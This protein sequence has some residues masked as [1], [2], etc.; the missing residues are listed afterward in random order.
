MSIST[1]PKASF[2]Y[3]ELSANWGRLSAIAADSMRSDPAIAIA[4]SRKIAFNLSLTLGALESTVL[5]SVSCPAVAKYTARKIQSRPIYA[6]AVKHLWYRNVWRGGD[7]PMPAL[8]PRLRCLW[9]GV[10]IRILSGV[11]SATAADP[12]AD[13]IAAWQ[14]MNQRVVQAYQAGRVSV[15]VPLAQQAVALA[16]SSF[17][18]KDPR[19]LTSMNNLAEVLEDQG[20][21][22]EAEPLLR[23][24]L[25]LRR[26][27]LGPRHPD[28]LTSTNNLALVLADQGR[29]GE[30]EPLYRETLQLRREVLGPRDPNTLTSI[31]NLALVLEDQGRY[32]EAEAL[33]RE[34]LQLRRE[35]LGPR[36]PNTLTS[37]NNLA[38][39]LEDQ[40]RYGEAEQLY[41]ETL[42]L[43]RE[44]LGLR[45]PDTLT[46]MNNLA[47]VLGDQGRYGEAEQLYRE[48]LQLRRE[49]LGL[50]HP[51]TLTSMNNL[52][53]V[54]GDQGRYGEAEPLY[55][56]ALYGS[57]ETLG[58]AHPATLLIQLN[59]VVDLAAQ[60][61]VGDAAALQRQ[62][63][64]QVLTWL[65]AELYTTEA[66]PVRRRLVASQ[67]T[68]QDVALSLAMLPGAG[69]DA[70]ELAAS[71][72]LRFKGLAVEEE[73]YLARL[74]RRGRD[75]R[76]RIVAT[77]VRQL[78][79]DLAKVFRGGGSGQA[80]KDLSAQLDAKELELGRTSRD[81][82]PY[83]QVRSASLQDLR[84]RLPPHSALLE[85]RAYQPADFKSGQLGPWRWAGVLIPADG[86]IEVRDLV[87]AT[88]TA[89]LVQALRDL[90]RRPA[91]AA[92][93]TLYRQLLAPFA[94][95][96]AKVQRL[97]VGPDELLYLVPFGLLRDASGARVLDSLDLRLVQTGRD[98]L[99]PPADYPAKGLVAVGGI[100]FDAMA[101]Q[102]SSA[103]LPAAPRDAAQLGR[104]RTATADAFAGGFPA[105]TRSKQEVEAIGAQYSLSRHDEPVA[106]V[107]GAGPTKSWLLAL[108]PPR[109]LH[110]ATH[111]FY[112][113]PKE[114]ADQPMLLAGVAL[115]GANHS[116]Q[117]DGEDGIL[118]AL[119]AEDLNLDGTELVVLSACDTALG[120]IDYGE[121][122]SGLVR[123]LRTAGAR[124]VLVTLRPVD[125]LGAEQFMQRFYFYWLR[126]PRSDPAAAL[127]DAQREA[128]K[129]SETTWTSFVMIGD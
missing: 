118:Y 4:H 94:A 77:E 129:D 114:P 92:A 103:A 111:G 64:A 87:A 95:R 32:G 100:D 123:A 61:R 24:T 38:A 85:L 126:Q 21:Y 51:D 70:G 91:E 79:Q 128:A 48:T 125:D 46:S 2:V 27:V 16:K 86:E 108:P 29:Y 88:D 12:S 17:G 124:N 83:L 102:P 122:V 41:R 52:A 15:A 57:R 71:A 73:A 49:V 90:L 93:A 45:H 99:R 10:A 63:E 14:T 110:L 22:G 3:S 30:A 81:Y 35:V 39:V 120:Q 98:L 76:T 8:L 58:P 97:Y 74:M 84:A 101:T 69:A 107:E 50:R 89:A 36:D 9:A 109:V 66:A 62:M 5:G 7:P 75:P 20:R 117:H 68:Y 119:E 43:R 121:G 60:G 19:T 116:L 105:L 96:L 31:N 56:D 72:L 59:L 40:G 65:G 112:L 33:Y 113:A 44:V 67:S 54:L 106:I 53:A 80:V 13:Q 28:T 104:L 127:R 1:Q 6:V 23:E 55:R 26:E 25:Q 115:A 11:V 18:P 42:Q 47:A 82:A 78:H 37:I 34:T